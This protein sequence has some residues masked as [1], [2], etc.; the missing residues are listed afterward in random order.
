MSGGGGV[1][2]AGGGVG[3]LGGLAG[4]VGGWIHGNN[5]ISSEQ[6]SEFE[7]RGVLGTLFGGMGSIGSDIVEELNDNFRR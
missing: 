4:A 5:K 6:S 1:I 2:L 3:V 7:D